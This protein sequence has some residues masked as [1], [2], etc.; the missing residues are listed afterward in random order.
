M[1]GGG[2]A[3]SMLRCRLERGGDRTKHC[4]KMKQ[5]QQ[6]CLCSIG[7]KRGMATSTGGKAAPGREKRG[8]DA[9]WDDT[10]FTGPKNEENPYG[11]FSC[12]KLT[13]KI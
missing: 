6:A 10:N 12:Y 4:R 7:R 11:R 2:G 3:D 5:R 8:D 13:V 9:S 1:A